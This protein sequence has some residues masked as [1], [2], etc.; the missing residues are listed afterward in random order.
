MRR[1]ACLL[2]LVMI[3]ALSNAQVSKPKTP[4]ERVDGIYGI[5][6]IVHDFMLALFDT[7]AVKG[8]KAVAGA[9]RMASKPGI[10]YMTVEF[11]SLACG[12]LIPYSGRPMDQAHKKLAIAPNHI[13]AA[14]QAWAKAVEKSKLDAADKKFLIAEFYQHLLAIANNGAAGPASASGKETEAPNAIGRDAKSGLLHRRLEASEVVAPGEPGSLY[15]RLGGIHRVAVLVS[16]WVDRLANNPAANEESGDGATSANLPAIKFFL[17]MQ[18]CDGI[19][20]PQKYVGDK[21]M[22][23]ASGLGLSDAGWKA[24]YTDL[25]NVLATYQVRPQEQNDLVL[26]LQKNQKESV[27]SLPL[28]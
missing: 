5:A 22:S 4:F 2:S 21:L 1:F 19:G 7:E 18:L 14:K 17:T 15:T 20:G 10:E 12:G 13:Q 6:P 8:S 27:L 28:R 11:M 23:P 16:D 26:Y 9:M 24:A 25:Q 3:T